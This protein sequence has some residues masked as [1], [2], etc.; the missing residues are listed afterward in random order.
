MNENVA[1]PE[2]WTAPTIPAGAQ[3]GFFGSYR[4]PAGYYDEMLSADGLLRPH[5]QS[6]AELFAAEGSGEFSRRWRQAQRLVHEHGV[7]FNPFG[8]PGDPPR[9]WQLDPLPVLIP[10]QEW[11]DVSAGLEQRARLLNAILRDLYGPQELLGRGLLPAEIVFRNPAFL[12]ACHG[13]RLPHDCFLHFYAADLARGPDGRWLILGDR[14]EAPSGSGFALENRIVI[15]R[16]LPDAFRKCRVERLAP[17]FLALRET[18]RRLARQRRDNPRVVLLSQGPGDANYFEDAYLARYLGYTLAYGDDLAV[19]NNRVMLKTLAGLLPVNVILRRPNAESCDP[20][21]LEENA[22]SGPAG[23]VEAARAGNVSI[24]NPLGSGL[25]ESPVLMSFLPA[26]C[27]TLLSEEPVLPGVA[28]WWCG[29]PASLD[30]ALANREQLIFRHAFRRRGREREAS[31][32]LFDMSSSELA[33]TVRSDPAMFIAQ[34]RVARSSTPVWND[35]REESRDRPAAERTASGKVEPSH[36]A[37]RTFL[38]ASG[39]SYVVMAGGLGRVSRGAEPLFISI[40]AGERSK[41]VWVLSEKPVSPISLLAH[42]GKPI[43]LRRSGAELPSRVADHVY[44]LGRQL[45]R[46]EAGARLLRAIGFRLASESYAPG[47]DARRADPLASLP[48]LPVLLRVLAAQ[49]QIEPGYV[50]EGIQDQLPA[51]ERALPAAVFDPH[52]PSGLRATA[53]QLLRAASVVRDRISL[54]AWKTILRIDEQFHE[55][56]AAPADLSTML[57]VADETIL[58][59]STF[60][61]MIMDSMTRT[62]TWRFLDLGRRVERA[63]ATLAILRH[64]LDSAAPAS[65]A[66]LEAVVEV[67]DSLMTYRS[68]YLANM[69]LAAVLDLLLIDETNPRS[70]AYQLVAIA[71]HVDALPRDRDQP[72]YAREQRLA[73][74]ALHTVR[75]VEIQEFADSHS[76][77]EPGML[78]RL[79]KRVEK[80]VRDLSEEVS[81]RYLIHAGELRQLSEIRPE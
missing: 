79:L 43:E 80:R 67:A 34:E 52:Q 12:R 57:A 58:G 48:E 78:E 38:V 32:R 9:P 45:E 5:W 16:M 7:A 3:P 17:Y 13:Q 64:A 30:Y 21:D 65:S 27:R 44:W 22:S 71:D 15:S 11:R 42:P 31:R 75:M 50:I 19:R 66:V 20:L 72:L 41:D 74:S 73:M 28:T 40:L 46:A 49:G 8:D 76:L 59:V 81:H 26:L 68:R 24:A 37:L 29:D 1:A 70:V 4:P 25:V 23:L 62:P 53:Q 18:L 47:L 51:I 63:L 69:Q 60:S 6:F 10:A 56:D 2:L 36:I 55:V 61:G 39:E 35:E 77:G 14:S 33:H 54:D